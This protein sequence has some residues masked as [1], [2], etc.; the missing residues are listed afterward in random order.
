M[1]RFEDWD[2]P[3]QPKK[4][5]PGLLRGIEM[6]LDFQRDHVVTH[7]MRMFRHCKYLAALA[8]AR[9]GDKIPALILTDKDNEVEG[10][11]STDTHYFLVVNLH[12]YIAESTGDPAV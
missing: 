7:G 12:R 8:H 2:P 3:F 1:S 4:G 6:H 10:E 9:C 5:G 11:F